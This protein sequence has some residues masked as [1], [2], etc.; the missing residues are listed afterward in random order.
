MNILEIEDMIKGLPDQALQKEAQQ[1][2]G[3]VPQFLVVSEIQR[4]SDMRKRF[5]ERQ[6]QG[7][8]KDQIVQQ[9]IAAMSPPNPE[10][11]A[12]MMSMPQ[13]QAAM[14]GVPAP[15]PQAM[16]QAMPPGVPMQQPPM[17]M[18]DG[19][20]VEMSNGGM[21][22]F[23]K[24]AAD[25]YDYR[26]PRPAEEGFSEAAMSREELIRSALGE[27]YQGFMPPAFPGAGARDRFIDQASARMLELEMMDQ[28][29]A[30]DTPLKFVAAN[31]PDPLSQPI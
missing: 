20:V 12:A 9:G 11:Q 27:D 13:Q 14:A 15:M 5:Q 24:A 29:T 19:G 26:R 21:T 28:E 1:P 31:Q 7:T 23:E 3:Q 10:M 18:Y 16:P 30:N 4:R 8:V 6:P 17:G 22:E 2:T 25:L